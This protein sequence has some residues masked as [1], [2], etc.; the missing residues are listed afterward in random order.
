M[1]RNGKN[2]S[3]ALLF[4]IFIIILLLIGRFLG[5]DKVLLTV[6]R[7]EKV[8][9]PSF[10][11]ITF[12]L[13]NRP[14]AVFPEMETP[15]KVTLHLPQYTPASLLSP[16]AYQHLAALTAAACLCPCSTCLLS[17]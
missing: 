11:L 1:F 6:G 8:R 9:L 10:R 4:F 2:A 7:L 13:E 17:Y 14:A 5:A 15:C 3:L 16:S 12:P